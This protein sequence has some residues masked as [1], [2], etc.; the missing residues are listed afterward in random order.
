[1][2]TNRKGLNLSDIEPPHVAAYVEEDD[3]APATVKQNLAALRRLFDF[4]VTGQVLEANPA[5]PVKGPRRV[6]REGSTPIL[7]AEETRKF[8][9]GLPT[10]SVKDKRD[11]A[12]IGVLT[13]TFARVSAIVRME[14]DD[15]YQAGRRWKVRLREKGGKH[16]DIP[17]HHKAKD[18]L[19][20]YLETTPEA[21][22]GESSTE[23]WET[24]NSVNSN[25]DSSPDETEN[26]PLFRT[27]TRRKTLSGR[28]MSRTSVL[29]MVKSRAKETG[30]DP[31]RVCCHTFR[32]TGI[33]AYLE[34][35]GKLEVAQHLAGHADGSTTKLYDRRR[36]I[37]SKEEVKKIGI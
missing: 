26:L 34:N 29:R 1:M 12:I 4:L 17:L 21:V 22:D 19:D 7:T 32:G 5:E 37:V 16:R 2:G 10:R 14:R 25:T 30:F 28:P 13:Y 8:I 36:E 9:E 35:G 33:T 15:Y 24:P 31:S 20:A 18:Y 3:R 11:K 23:S 6:Q 27:M